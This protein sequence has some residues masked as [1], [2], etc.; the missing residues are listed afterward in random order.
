MTR[1]PLA[2]LLLLVPATASADAL[3]DLDAAY[4]AGLVEH[5]ELFAAVADAQPMTTRAG[6]LRFYGDSPL[7][8]DAAV[9]AIAHRLVH[10]DDDADVRRALAERLLRADASW[11]GVRLRVLRT[12]ASAF[13]RAMVV[14]GFRHGSLEGARA[15][16]EVALTDASPLVRREAASAVAHRP[17]GAGLAPMLVDVLADADAGVRLQ[18]VRA[19]D[20]QAPEL[21]RSAPTLPSLL[22]DADPRVSRAASRAAE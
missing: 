4:Q 9:P 20:V 8:Q 11:D 2:L 14:A 19:L 1:F 13:V 16:V 12:D 17:D 15:G 5:P 3:G 18:A 21:L 22:E 10:G 6:T 7:L